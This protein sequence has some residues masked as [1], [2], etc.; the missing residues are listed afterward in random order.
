MRNNCRSRRR[1]S[2]KRISFHQLMYKCFPQTDSLRHQTRAGGKQSERSSSSTWVF[3]SPL[4]I[5]NLK[6]TCGTCFF[7]VKKHPTWSIFVVFLCLQGCVFFEMIE[8]NIW[9]M[10]PGPSPT[11]RN[12]SWVML[13]VQN[14]H[15]P[16]AWLEIFGAQSLAHLY[17]LTY[18]VDLTGWLKDSV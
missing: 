8:L 15:V 13:S 12:R 7:G 9:R 17:A 6:E 18:N 3:G 5:I 16:L 4:N 11:I 14:S 1:S 10:L 2:T